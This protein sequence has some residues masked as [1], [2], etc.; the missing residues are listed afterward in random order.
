MQDRAGFGLDNAFHDDLAGSISDRHRN[1]FLVY[2]HADLFS[3]DHKGVPPQERLSE[4]SNLLHKGRP[5]ILPRLI[6]KVRSTTH[7]GGNSVNQDLAGFSS[8]IGRLLRFFRCL[9]FL[10][11]FHV[12]TYFRSDREEHHASAHFLQ[13]F[14]IVSF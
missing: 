2:V 9:L 7:L 11:C 10:W 5:F 3:A 6:G 12:R 14:G 8:L 4:H 13:I 1:A